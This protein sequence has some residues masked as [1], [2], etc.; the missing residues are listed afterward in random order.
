MNI[1]I[2]TILQLSDQDGSIKHQGFLGSNVNGTTIQPTFP[3]QPTGDSIGHYIHWGING[4]CS[5][6]LNLSAETVGGH[7]FWN[8][9][10][11]NAPLKMFSITKDFCLLDTLL[12]NT[13]DIVNLDMINNQLIISNNVRKS[14]LDNF[15]LVVENID[16]AE[17]SYIKSDTISIVND[18]DAT[19][20]IMSS[21]YLKINEQVTNKYSQLTTTNLY[22]NDVSIFTKQISTINQYFSASLYLDGEDPVSPPNTIVNQYAY[23]PS[24]YFKNTSPS[25]KYI[26]WRVETNM[27]VSNIL[28]LYLSFFNGVNTNAPTITIYTTPTG[29][30][31]YSPNFHSSMT[32]IYDGILTSNTRY[33]EFINILCSEPNHYNSTLVNM[34]QSVVLGNYS[35]LQTVSHFALGSDQTAPA[36]TVE[37]AI[38]KFGIITASGTI[39]INY[40]PQ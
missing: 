14:T 16:T 3:T 34:T 31:D 22:F 8:S 12:K 13:T 25:G 11:T 18:L 4:S 15:N 27:F 17:I 19:S 40:F 38:S 32:Y 23:S 24:W 7:N 6:H 21:T 39:E 1:P 36:N 10:S 28:G 5:E 33:T 35:P 9:T 2:N 26:N 29:S 20:N 30:G 37:F